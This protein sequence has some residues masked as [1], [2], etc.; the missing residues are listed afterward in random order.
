MRVVDR[1]F[2]GQS[3]AM[4]QLKKLID[5]CAR[6]DASVLIL[7]DTGVGKEVI[8]RELHLNSPRSNGPLVPINCAAIPGP[9]LESELFGFTKGSFT[10][11]ISDRPG[12]FE[13][14]NGG[15]LFLDE[16]GDMPLELQAK[17][18][19]VLE[20]RVVEPLGG[21]RSKPIDVRVIAA[22]HRNLEQMVKENRFRQDLYFRLNVLPLRIPSVVERRDDILAMCQFF[23]KKHA[24]KNRPITFTPQS[25]GV[26]LAYDW[27]GNVREISNLMMRFSVLFAGERIDISSLPDYLLPEG[28]LKIINEGDCEPVEADVSSEQIN[29]G[30]AHY[31]FMPID[32]DNNAN[33]LPPTDDT[34]DDIS[35][36]DI[37]R[38]LR[39]SNSIGTIPEEGIKA[40]Q[41]MADIEIQLITVALT[42]SKGSVSQAA[43]LLHMQRTTLIQKIA[44]YNIATAFI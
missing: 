24:Q 23:A 32:E 9:L 12:R 35:P 2:Y 3:E 16:I 11:A 15:T 34:D 39:L 18:L 37:E 6:S 21:G 7:G 25:A 1:I 31:Q 38:T 44:R 4:T 28:L 26:L 27:P 43:Q 17:M 22:T 33:G 20:E 8:S 41:F 13:L 30:A 29:Q 14:A 10:G 36:L 42:K 5:T 19:R 40:K